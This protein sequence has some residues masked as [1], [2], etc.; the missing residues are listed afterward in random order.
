M[1]G[2]EHPDYEEELKRLDITL[3][4]LKSYNDRI[5]ADKNKIDSE[6]EYGLSHYNS[7]NAE[8]FNDLSI[9]YVLQKNLEYKVKGLE[10]SMEKPYFAR[11]D[12][13]EQ[14]KDKLQQLYIGK[15]SLMDD[16]T[17]EMIIVDWRSPVATLYYE[18]RL[19][20]AQYQC[21]DGVISGNIS[22][23]RQYSI[24]KSQIKEI[25]DIDITTNDEFLQASLNSL[26]DNRL[27]D[28]VSTIQEEQN[29]VIRANM[30]RPLLVQGAAG[31]GKTTIALHRIAYL[32]YN[33]EK[34]VPSDGFMIIA[35][36]RFF[37][38]YI[39]DV[40]PELGVHSVRQNTFE[41]FALELIEEKFDIKDPSEK[42]R[43]IIEGDMR[44]NKISSFKSSIEYKLMLDKFLKFIEAKYIPKLDFKIH[45]TVIY[46][47]K[48][49]K[50]LFTNSYNHL[51]FEKRIIEIK[52]H[53][54]NK[55]KANKK[56]ILQ[57]IEDDY[58]WRINK[59]RRDM[60]DC[61]ERRAKIIEI[62]DE[63]DITVKR[64]RIKM[65]SL[66]REYFDKI[67]PLR[68]SDYYKDFM[69]M[70]K[71][72]KSEGLVAKLAEQ[73]VTNIDSKSIDIEDLAP[74]MYIKLKIYGL[75]EKLNLRHIVIDEAQDFSVFQF[76]VLKEVLGSSSMTIL[77]D[78]CQGIYSY[79]G[80]S[81]WD[82]INKAIFDG[83]AEMLTLEQSYRT[84]VEIMS[85]AT[86]I[87]E[88]IKERQLPLA[89]P[90]IR[91]GEVIKI[92][93]LSDIEELALKI[94][95]DVD[96][97]KEKGYKSLALIC[98]NIEECRKLKSIIDNFNI[99]TTMVTGGESDF[100]GGIV[101]IPTYLV[102]GLEFD[103]VIICNASEQM[104]T[105][106]ELDIKL[107]YVA[108]TRPL[109]YLK[110]Y[111]VGQISKLLHQLV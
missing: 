67:V 10:S 4:Y 81:D 36:N 6:V 64:A 37:L 23:K 106:S 63:R 20:E 103:M 71:Y 77:G 39:S 73:T 1:A 52:K 76:L 17:N 110:I 78:I 22:I 14:Y 2:T 5:L 12:F 8:Q 28:I 68:V 102:K 48:E 104:Y 96:L 25:Y 16:N 41:D 111:H 55:L 82:Y 60:D 46:S 80:T 27:K 7:D 101:I 11:V 24:E 88:N 58:D 62:A 109:H 3:K 79:R 83:E 18:G 75:E 26:K 86:K 44:S 35:P 13:K 105:D 85:G 89:K 34:T 30:W 69:Y 87:L 59:L 42:L 56:E 51:P 91:H 47:Y 43:S 92:E 98:K 90:V 65:G 99:E 66:I 108:M 45:D 95:A 9:N 19:G 107:L 53:L 57:S 50:S 21:E 70:L 97:W 29:R 32:L 49:I 61:P 93:G 94:N 100:S 15:V 38:S 31:G 40:L 54:T 33:Y 84:T 72:W 74:L